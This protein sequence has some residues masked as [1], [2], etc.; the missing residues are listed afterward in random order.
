MN[1]S[2]ITHLRKAT[3]KG[4]TTLFCA[5][6]LVACGGGGGGSPEL[7][8][9]HALPN[10]LYSTTP[11]TTLSLVAGA[12]QSFTVGGGTPYYNATSSNVNV[13]T[14]SLSGSTLT[15]TGVAGGSAQIAVFDAVGASVSTTVTV[16][17][18]PGSSAAVTTPT[19][20]LGLASA[21]TVVK[22]TGLT[23]ATAV[24]KD[25]SGAAVPGRLVTFSGDSALVK[26]IPAS[27]QTLSN[28]SGVAS[29]E[30]APVSLTASGASTLVATAM[31]GEESVA[32]AFDF[33]FE[34]ANLGLSNLAL[35]TTVLPAYGSRPV[36]VNVTVNGVAATASPV[37]VTFS[38]TCGTVVPSVVTSDVVTGIASA[39]YTASDPT[40]SGANVT[41][42]ASAVGAGGT[43]TRSGTLAVAASQ[44]SNVLFVSSTPQ[45]LYLAGSVGVTQA[46]VVFKVV[47]ASGAALQN[48]K[49][50]VALS[51]TASGGTLNT[52]GNTGPVD[53]TSDGA[54][55]VS[56]TVFSGTVPTSLNLTATLLDAADAVTGVFSS[57]NLLTVAS[58]KPTQRSLSL[59]PD[60]LSIEAAIR[61]G[62]T[63]ALTLS[64]ADR[65][66]NPVPA[67]TQVNFVTEGGVISPAS[68]VVA[69][70]TP[71]V[72]SC[73]VTLTSSGTR[74]ANG[75]VSVLA[76]VAGE[77][78]FVDVNGNNVHDAGESFTDLGRAH[79]DDNGQSA[80]GTDGVYTAGEF[81]LPRDGAPVCVAGQVCAGDAVWGAADVRQQTT[82]V[83]ATG[84][85]KITATP[86]VAGF[87][88]TVSDQNNNSL[89]TGS[90]I[91]VSVI[92]TTTI[93]GSG[94]CTLTSQTSLTVLNTI[95][96]WSVP[97]GLTGCEAGDVVSIIVTT[98]VG[99]ITP[100]DLSL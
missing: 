3:T 7:I 18:A 31:L 76:Y 19:V 44:A 23:T 88:A 9:G 58:G 48:Q 27:G 57:S 97:V 100:R 13:A 33:E 41:V 67:G 35:G 78:D 89:P 8:P 34:S 6:S 66:G 43:V 15:I 75:L 92:D 85:A 77:E 65:Q 42:T 84:I 99:T 2:K 56:A 37:Q 45:T 98:P 36:S 46:Q 47:D 73:S 94:T 61:D 39:T 1:F 50:R 70:A 38:A 96:A 82:V 21:T 74:T 53:L 59:A 25:A 71:P 26:F 69:A 49:L 86:V 22:A 4:L 29:I 28:S 16:T 52:V 40:C 17:G 68:C 64:M 32:S 54:G 62:E 5:L 83:F 51:S 91:A 80:T 63:T 87:T 72:S 93:V 14:A 12:S 90:T 24:L 60:K 79:R 95:A 81:Q 30:V 55:L 20:T 10:A 11:S